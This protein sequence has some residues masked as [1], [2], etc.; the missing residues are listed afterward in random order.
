MQL[1]LSEHCSEPLADIADGHQMM[2]L[3]TPIHTF[4]SQ[5]AHLYLLPE[6]VIDESASNGIIKLLFGEGEECCLIGMHSH[7]LVQG[8][9]IH[10]IVHFAA[11]HGLVEIK[12]LGRPR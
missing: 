10:I 2:C 8:L 4:R 5:H 12:P 6:K 9:P 1:S 7:Q 3:L 11:N